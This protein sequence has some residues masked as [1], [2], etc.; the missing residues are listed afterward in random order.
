MLLFVVCVMMV[1][2]NEEFVSDFIGF[3]D[4]MQEVL[5][6]FMCYFIVWL[7]DGVIYVIG[8]YF[9][10]YLCNVDDCVDVVIV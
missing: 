8:D 6:G 3:W 5:C 10:V 9:V 1:F 7:F 4:F 2:V